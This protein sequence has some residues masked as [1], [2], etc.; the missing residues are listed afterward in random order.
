MDWS[1]EI[2]E[3]LAAL[4]AEGMTTAKIAEV[5]SERFKI[6]PP[7]TKNA[8]VGKKNRLGLT[9]R[10]S[11]IRVADPAKPR[12]P[13]AATRKAAAKAAV[14]VAIN[15]PPPLPM[16]VG[17]VRSCCWPIGEPKQKGF[18]FCDA[19]SR[20]GRSYC[21][22]HMRIAYVVQ[23]MPAREAFYPNIVAR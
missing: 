21:A 10:E 1:D 16:T 5:L 19:P 4:W 12:L 20:P 11:P 13:S 15:E 3:T 18:H 9:S 22:D 7:L 17:P 14:E 2:N 23:S 6:R 8:I